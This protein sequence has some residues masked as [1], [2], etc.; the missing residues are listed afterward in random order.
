MNKS[1]SHRVTRE[2]I[3]QVSLPEWPSEALQGKLTFLISEA[4]LKF[5]TDW[6]L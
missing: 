2:R 6:D 5:D 3:I 4:W 1:Y